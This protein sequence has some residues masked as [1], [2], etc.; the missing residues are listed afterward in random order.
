MPDVKKA[1]CCYCGRR[2]VLRN[3]A[4]GGH[5]LACGSC[6]APL[7][8]MKRLRPVAASS[9]ASHP[10]RRQPARIKK[11]KRRRPLWR[12]MA[13]ELWDEIEDIFD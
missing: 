5:E 6:G 2:T 1:T 9:A 10:P 12:K 7:H 11:E 8:V 4:H 13:A 3:T